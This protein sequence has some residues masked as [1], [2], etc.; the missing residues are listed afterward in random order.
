MVKVTRRP[1]SSRKRYSAPNLHEAAWAPEPVWTSVKNLLPP[2]GFESR[3][4]HPV[5]SRYTDYA[6]LAPTSYVRIQN[7][8]QR[9]KEKN[10]EAILCTALHFLLPQQ[11]ILKTPQCK[12][13]EFQGR[14]HYTVPSDTVA[15]VEFPIRNAESLLAPR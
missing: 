10:G 6:N 12:D 13:T 4:V 9:A 8:L 7:I 11:I 14:S 1:L 2:P 5:A 15:A 3:T